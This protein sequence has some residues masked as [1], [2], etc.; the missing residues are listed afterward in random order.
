[1]LSR[2]FTKRE[3]LLMLLLAVV[4]LCL[5]YNQFVKKPVERR[6][7]A[8]DTTELEQQIGTEESRAERIRAMRA[9]MA[10]N[11]DGGSGYVSTYNNFNAEANALNEIIQAA[12]SFQFSFRQ[13]VAT[14]DVV[15]RE[16]GI[17]FTAADYRLARQI[18][19]Q[20]H[21]LGYRC[22]IQNVELSADRGRRYDTSLP[23]G[24]LSLENAAVRCSLNIIFYETLYD[25]DTEEGLAYAEGTA[26]GKRGGLANADVSG[27]VRSDLETAAESWA[28]GVL[29]G[30]NG[31]GK[32]PYA[33][34]YAA[35]SR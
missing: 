2:A 32:N 6:I 13:P 11:R 14:E 20:I 24:E 1:M 21:D 4:L 12:E 29:Y 25:A 3:K 30:Q 16:I 5:F 10:A 15:R 8:A 22:L 7:A 23:E 31:T 35:E 34:S 28:S 18:L 17:S 26:P 33:E 27:I 9:E 19:Q